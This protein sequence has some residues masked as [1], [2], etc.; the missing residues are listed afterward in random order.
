MASAVVTS[1]KTKAN[2]PRVLVVDDES[3]VSETIK[4]LIRS[5]VECDMVFAD[6]VKAAR[7]AI[8]AG[9]PFDLMLTDLH[10]P[11]G[12]GM[13]LLPALHEATP[14]ASAIVI[15]GVATVDNAVKAIRGGAVDFLPKPFTGSQLVERVQVALKRNSII[16]KQG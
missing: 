3:V 16:V 12:N 5:G 11:D 14:A 6:S 1:G 9:E 2:L 4:D 15:T 13:S 10:L 7:S 8:G